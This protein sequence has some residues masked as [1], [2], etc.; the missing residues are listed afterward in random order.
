MNNTV[1]TSVIGSY[2]VKIDRQNLMSAYEKGVIPPW[3]PYIKKAVFSMIQSELDMISDGQTRDPFIHILIRGL[4]GCRI[5]QRPEVIGN[6]DLVE[7]ITKNDLLYVSRIIPKDSKLVGL[8]VGPCTL[9][10]SVVDLYYHDK[11]E[12]AFAF[13]KALKKE[14]RSIE[15]IVDMISIDEPFFAN[16]LPEYSKELIS[17]MIQGLDCPTRLH[18]CGDVSSIVGLLVDFPIDILSHEFKATPKLFEIFQQ[19]PSK[20]G[21]CLGSV[22]SDKKDVE[23]VDDIINHIRTGIKIFESQIK[24][25]APDCG[26][27]LLPE[28]IAF[29]KL[30]NL[31]SAKREIY[32]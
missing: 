9:S 8:I 12:L 7:P 26:L 25:I 4:I 17:M 10:E 29:Q 19:Y 21:I 3:N 30:K 16:M 14:I 13:A 11:K 31:V 27:R 32:G 20:K 6:I 1:V 15:P 5:R 24:Q 23:S 18:V 2:P 22:R 28:D